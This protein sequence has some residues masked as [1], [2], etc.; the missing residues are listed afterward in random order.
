VID[1]FTF[2]FLIPTFGAHRGQSLK[3]ALAMP[4]RRVSQRLH[5]DE[6]LLQTFDQ[7]QPSFQ[8]P[9]TQ[10]LPIIAKAVEPSF[11]NIPEVQLQQAI[12]STTS[13]FP[14]Q[15]NE[16]EQH[17]NTNPL[18]PPSQVNQSEAEF[19]QIEV[20]NR[21][22]AEEEEE[23]KANESELIRVQQEIERLRQEQETIMRRQEVAQCTEAQRQHI[24]RER[25]RLAD[26]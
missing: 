21:D 5:P 11:D 19:N 7:N 24:N 1:T 22:E 13:A 3:T 4:P 25:A 18:P 17:L 14:C 12:T 10:T 9:S 16:G 8:Q 26:L 23:V 15:S 2:G 20:Q 6:G